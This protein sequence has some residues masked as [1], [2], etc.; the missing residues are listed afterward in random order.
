MRVMS[1]KK[2]RINVDPQSLVPSDSV[3]KYY[4]ISL[5]MTL[6]LVGTVSV[7]H[8]YLPHSVPIF[9]T[10]PWGVGRLAPKLYLY[11]LPAISLVVM[12]INILIGKALDM[13]D[14]KVLIYSLAIG[15]LVVTSTLTVSFLGIV[16]SIL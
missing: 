11:V 12:T 8:G 4:L 3:R 6:V 1:K 13:T 14:H 2:F 16:Q 9:F 15:S 5:V 10:E 7:V